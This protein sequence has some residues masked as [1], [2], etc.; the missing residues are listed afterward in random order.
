MFDER[1]VRTIL[2][3]T[4]GV[5][6][7]SVEMHSFTIVTGRRNLDQAVIQVG[8]RVLLPP[9]REL[10]TFSRE[11]KFLVDSGKFNNLLQGAGISGATP[12]VVEPLRAISP[13][14]F[15]CDS[16]V[17][18]CPGKPVMIDE[19]EI[20]DTTSSVPLEMV[21]YI[22]S[23]LL[24]AILCCSL[25]LCCYLTR[26]RH[27]KDFLNYLSSPRPEKTRGQESAANPLDRPSN[28]RFTTTE[29]KR[30]TSRSMDSHGQSDTASIRSGKT[31]ATNKTSVRFTR[32]AASDVNSNS[33]L[34]DRSSVRS[35]VTTRSNFTSFFQQ[36]ESSTREPH[37]TT[38]LDRPNSTRGAST[39]DWLPANNAKTYHAPSKTEPS[40]LQARAPAERANSVSF[41]D[42]EDTARTAGSFTSRQTMED[43]GNFTSR[44]TSAQLN[45]LQRDQRILAAKQHGLMSAAG[46]GGEAAASTRREA[47]LSPTSLRANDANV[48]MDSGASPA[49]RVLADDPVTAALSVTGSDPW[50]NRGKPPQ[51]WEPGTTVNRPNLFRSKFALDP[52]EAHPDS[53]IRDWLKRTTTQPSI[54]DGKVPEVTINYTVKSRVAKFNPT[55][56]APSMPQYL[57][58]KQALEDLESEPQNRGGGEWAGMPFIRPPQRSVGVT[59]LSDVR[60]EETGHRPSE[61]VDPSGPNFPRHASRAPV[62]SES[63]LPALQH[64]GARA[65]LSTPRWGGQGSG[66][67]GYDFAITPRPDRGSVDRLRSA[68]LNRLRSRQQGHGPEDG[69]G[70]GGISGEEEEREGVGEGGGRGGG[71][72]GAPSTFV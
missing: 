31:S 7:S 46:L 63:T 14:G 61:Q 17:Q 72:G 33:D 13:N 39:T 41:A 18:V 19:P 23:S 67:Q 58:S 21:L 71:E 56:D 69:R 35:G 9:G 30:A 51:L 12:L 25:S 6:A 55:E 59:W 29:S 62:T 3:Q 26:F 45:K 65:D 42:D 15:V 57:T 32:G 2:A 64:Q 1:V 44:H 50:M 68:L 10:L 22:V 5:D 24:A 38:L 47:Q 40:G 43:F 48:P 4:F 70:E 28:L 16:T 27:L 52:L 20:L 34:G 11:M 8:F 36:L 53:F 37:G 66:S 60:R 54:T 49:S